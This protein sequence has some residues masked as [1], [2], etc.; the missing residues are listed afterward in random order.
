MSEEEPDYVMVDNTTDSFQPAGRGCVL[1]TDA[2]VKHL[3]ERARLDDAC[4]HWIS[5]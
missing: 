3:L 4:V 1:L 5:G 2:L